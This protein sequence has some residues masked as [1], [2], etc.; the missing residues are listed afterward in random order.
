VRFERWPLS[1]GE[2]PRVAAEPINAA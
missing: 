2:L 1:P